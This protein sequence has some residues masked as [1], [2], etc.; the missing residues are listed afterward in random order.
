MEKNLI[1]TTNESRAISMK[2]TAG[3]HLRLLAQSAG[4]P[5]EWLR[6]YYS[7]V[8]EKPISRKQTWLMI[9]AQ[10]AFALG[11]LPMDSPLWLR[12]VYMGWFAWSVRKCKRAGI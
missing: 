1:L 2:E 7:H 10:V 4:K 8:L 12:A 6:K 3:N 5:V 9:E 11:I